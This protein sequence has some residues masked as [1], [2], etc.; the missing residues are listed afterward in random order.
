MSDEKTLDDLNPGE[1]NTPSGAGQPENKAPESK[2]DTGLDEVETGID[3][4]LQEGDDDDN[5]GEVDQGD[6]TVALPTATLMKL[7]T[8]RDNYRQGL[9]SAKEKIRQSKKAQAERKQTEGKPPA[10]SEDPPVT[11]SDN[12]KSNSKTAIAAFTKKTLPNGEENSEYSED[13][14]THW[15]EVLVYYSPRH[16]K[17]TVNGIK[18]DIHDAYLLF[19]QKT[20]KKK[21]KEDKNAAANAANEEGTPSGGDKGGKPSEGRKHVLP[22]QTSASEWYPGKKKSE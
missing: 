16:G 6:D 7:K 19:R 4:L 21:E 12:E 5:L 8:D 13:I 17:D 18:E 9:L 15:K 14:D 10:I 3:A 11:K 1:D 2:P 22:R 20:P